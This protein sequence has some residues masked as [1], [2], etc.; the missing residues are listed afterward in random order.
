M[1][2]LTAIDQRKVTDV[3][4]KYRELTQSCLD[5]EYED[6]ETGEQETS[7]DQLDLHRTGQESIHTL[8]GPGDVGEGPGKTRNDTD[9][10][11]RSWTASAHGSTNKNFK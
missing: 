11:G 7:V 6:D 5:P 9:R 3:I 1:N 10:N 2:T 8:N 4:E